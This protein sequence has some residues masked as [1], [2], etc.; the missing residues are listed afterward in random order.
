MTPGDVAKSRV[1][2]AE[3]VTHP[4]WDACPVP[5]NV[6]VKTPGTGVGDNDD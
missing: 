5:V 2:V 6:P 1:S 4:R 3:S